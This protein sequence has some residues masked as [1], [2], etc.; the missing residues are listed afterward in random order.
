MKI[1]NQKSELAQ[2]VRNKLG[3]PI[4]DVPLSSEQLDDVIDDAVQYFGHHA[5][6]IGHEEQY[7]LI[8]VCE[9]RDH[10]DNG[11]LVDLEEGNCNE[12]DVSTASGT[13][14]YKRYRSEYQLPRNVEAIMQ[15]FPGASNAIAGDAQ[16]LNYGAV[17]AAVGA[18]GALGSYGYGYY[19]GSGFG[20]RGGS[21][22]NSGGFGIDIVSFEIGMEYLEMWRQRYSLKLR[23]QFLEQTRKVRFSPMPTGNVGGTGTILLGVWAKV[24]DRWLYEHIWVKNYTLALAK[25]QVASNMQLFGNMAFPGG[26]QLNYEVFEKQGS[27]MK[28]KLEKE[29]TDGKYSYPP[30]FIVG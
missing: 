13:G 23:A 14:A 10:E 26:T 7:L 12:Y 24:A 15:E 25:L 3:S 11:S 21:R 20:T 9:D 8:D 30:D 16:L 27:E 6:G 19:M 5:G 28:E 1:Y 2:W 17:S 22:N 18:V 29:L 4:I